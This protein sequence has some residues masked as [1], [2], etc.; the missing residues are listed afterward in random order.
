VN[1]TYPS[2]S[3][4]SANYSAVNTYR[5]LVFNYT[6]INNSINTFLTNL[7]Q[8]V[9]NIQ[10]QIDQISTSLTNAQAQIL[11]TQT[12][13]APIQNPANQLLA[14]AFCGFLGND[15]GSIKA[16]YCNQISYGCGIIAM[17]CFIIGV[18]TLPVVIMST[19]LANL[20]DRLAVTGASKPSDADKLNDGVKMQ[21][22]QVFS[23]SNSLL[24]PPSFVPPPDPNGAYSPYQPVNGGSQHL[25]QPSLSPP[26]PAEPYGSYSQPLNPPLPAYA[27][28]SQPIPYEGPSNPVS[29]GFAPSKNMSASMVNPAATPSA[30]P[31]YDPPS[32]SGGALLRTQS[33]RRSQRG[34]SDDEGTH[35]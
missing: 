15:Y 8:N 24:P 10:T 7:K 22:A 2:V 17:C 27:P 23:S 11:H 14:L 34:G 4:S 33:V 12:L 32:P 1:S 6:G 35:P 31:Q 18:F 29:A 16:T 13:L 30:P 25:Y 28:P 5:A 20:D 21:N 19:K 3:S 26:L 9:S